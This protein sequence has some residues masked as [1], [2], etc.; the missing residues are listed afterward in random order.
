[1][2]RVWDSLNGP[3]L[4]VHHVTLTWNPSWHGEPALDP[5]THDL[6]F[7]FFSE[8]PIGNCTRPAAARAAHG[9]TAA[10]IANA[11]SRSTPHDHA[12]EA[13]PCPTVIGRCHLE[14]AT[15][16]GDSVEHCGTI[17]ENRTHKRTVGLFRV[18]PLD[19]QKGDLQV[20]HR[21]TDRLDK[22]GT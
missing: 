16:A 12:R 3:D 1:M 17:K 13:L 6:I 22:V 21:L 2:G 8:C 9:S 5:Q 15:V 19:H 14:A 7:L 20:L 10:G 11:D 4:R 18:A